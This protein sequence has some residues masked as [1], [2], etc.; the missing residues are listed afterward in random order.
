MVDICYATK[1]VIDHLYFS[2]VFRRMQRDLPEVHVQRAR[3]AIVLL[4][5]SF[6]SLPFD[7]VSKRFLMQHL[8]YENEFDSHEDEPVGGMHFHMNGSRRLDRLDTV[9]DGNS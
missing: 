5:R 1:Q 4:K 8:S 7:S 2:V 6:P 3:R 9:V